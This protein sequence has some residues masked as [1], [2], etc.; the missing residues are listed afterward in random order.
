MKIKLSLLCFLLIGV[1][2]NT[3][4]VPASTDFEDHVNSEAIEI[5][6]VVSQPLTKSALRSQRK[7]ARKE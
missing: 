3:G 7:A 4:A 2:T 6:S 1:L 5:G